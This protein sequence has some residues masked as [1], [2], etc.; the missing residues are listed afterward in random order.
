MISQPRTRTT[1]S[2]SP[3][4]RPHGTRSL[5]SPPPPRA[6]SSWAPLP[7]KIDI[8]TEEGQ[9]CEILGTGKVVSG[10]PLEHGRSTNCPITMQNSSGQSPLFV[11]P[12][13]YRIGPPCRWVGCIVS[14]N[15]GAAAASPPSFRLFRERGETVLIP[16]E[17]RGETVVPLSQSVTH[18]GLK[19]VCGRPLS[20]EDVVPF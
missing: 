3:L 5:L 15:N 1:D 14:K 4:R 11:Y 6:Q 19:A 2:P 17:G 12:Y 7:R 10:S 13:F 20:A 16:G 8:R 18:V 9:T